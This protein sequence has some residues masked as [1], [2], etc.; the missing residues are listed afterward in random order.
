VPTEADMIL[1]VRFVPNPYFVEHLRPQTGED[2]PVSDF[3]LQRPE[4]QAFLGHTRTFLQFL[5]PHYR[6]E[7]KCYFTVAIGCTGGRHRSVA[8]ARQVAQSLRQ[9][10]V[11]VDLRHRDITRDNEREAP[12]KVPS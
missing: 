8:L 12:Q 10:G 1:D 2:E 9:D 11:T 5:L 7:G 4:A 6:E 3:V